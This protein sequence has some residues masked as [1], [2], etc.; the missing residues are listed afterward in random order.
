[1]ATIVRVLTYITILCFVLSA[2]FVGFYA[3]YGGKHPQQ[4]VAAEEERIAQNKTKLQDAFL[5]TGAVSLEDVTRG[6]WISYVDEAGVESIMHVDVNALSKYG[7]SESDIQE[8]AGTIKKSH[9]ASDTHIAMVPEGKLPTNLQ[10]HNAIYAIG[11]DAPTTRQ[12][13][14]SLEKRTGKER[15]SDVLFQLS[16]LAELEGDYARRDTLRAENCATFKQQCPV[17]KSAPSSRLVGVVVDAKGAP[18]QGATVTVISRPQEHLSVTTDQHGAYV[19]PLTLTSMEKLRVKAIKRNFSDGYENVVAVNPKVTSLRVNP[20][21]LES[22]ITITTIDYAARTVTGATNVFHADGTVV[23]HSTNSTYTLPKRPLV[24][25]NGTPW[26]G[27]VVDVYLYEFSKGAPP[28][29][30]MQLD[31]FDAVM[32]YAGNLMKTFGMPYIQFFDQS[33]GEELHVL[34]SNPMILEYRIADMDALRKNTDHIY[35]ALTNDDM[36]KL[37]SYSALHPY[38]VD[39]QYLIDSQL[40][41]F[42]AFWVFD[43]ARGVWDNIGV[44]VLTEEGDIRTQFYT[45]RDK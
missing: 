35:R 45:L 13:K 28:T 26:T 42:P 31:T 20:V 16:Y 32:G 30:L 14:A 39:R 22:P 36:K 27:D 10:F 43:R 1:M 7:L 18:V 44:S 19:I 12:M 37:V 23:I 41:V 8:I 29:S 17:A 40:L 25:S 33:T 11:N 3:L 4:S 15:T 21:R 6:F 5:A 9:V 2:A 24:H 38:G 34:R